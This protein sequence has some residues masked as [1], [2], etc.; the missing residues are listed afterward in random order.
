MERKENNRIFIALGFILGVYAYEF[1]L[2]T[3]IPAIFQLIKPLS[4][5]FVL[6]S[7]IKN[8][9]NDRL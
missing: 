1:I 5:L 8:S 3:R 9:L 7:L 2:F 6:G 4:A